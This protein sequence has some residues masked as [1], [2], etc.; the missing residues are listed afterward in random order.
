MHQ[1]S[2]ANSPISDR[3]EFAGRVLLDRPCLPQDGYAFPLQ[4]SYPFENNVGAQALVL[5]CAWQILLTKSTRSAASSVIRKA[6]W[7][8]EGC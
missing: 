4:D 8:L 6:Q 5:A 3:Q 1:S 7:N 2:I